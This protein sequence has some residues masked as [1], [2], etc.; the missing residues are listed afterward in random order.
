MPT[1]VYKRTDEYKQ[2]LS[3]IAKTR[4]FGQWMKGKH[5]SEDTKQKLSKKFKGRK[6]SEKQKK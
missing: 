1:G 4:G 3:K 6:I 2:K 5:L